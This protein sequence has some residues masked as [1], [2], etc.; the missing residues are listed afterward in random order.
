VIGI[1]DRIL[2]TNQIIGV[3][4]PLGHAECNDLDTVSIA[5]RILVNA[6]ILAGTVSCPSS[7]GTAVF[8]DG[9]TR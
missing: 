5:D 3:H 1:A 2:M 6:L 8:K 9:F 7:T 4:L